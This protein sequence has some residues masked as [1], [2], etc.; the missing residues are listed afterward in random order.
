MALPSAR[1]QPP[2]ND[3][4]MRGAQFSQAWGAFFQ[5]VADQS[6]TAAAFAATT[7][8]LATGPSYANDAAAA[9]GG[10]GI[11]ILY[12]SGSQICIRVT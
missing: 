10:V 1:N 12:R 9:V 7:A 11:G 3:P 6:S 5:D 8:A 2:V 4:P